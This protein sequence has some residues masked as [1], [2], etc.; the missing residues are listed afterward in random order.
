MPSIDGGRSYPATIG[1]GSTRG[2]EMSLTVDPSSIIY[3]PPI[4]QALCCRDFGNHNMPRLLHMALIWAGVVPQHPPIMFAP[5]T[6]NLTLMS[7]ISCGVA[8]KTV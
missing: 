6:R 8:L 2:I 5:A 1:C 4:K 7:A 3:S